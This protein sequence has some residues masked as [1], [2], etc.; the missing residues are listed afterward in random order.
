LIQDEESVV[1]N[2][3]PVNNNSVD[4]YLMAVTKL[5]GDH[6]KI[7]NARL[8]NEIKPL[9]VAGG[10]WAFVKH[11]DWRKDGRGAVMALRKQAEGNSAK[12]TRKAKA[13]VSLSNARY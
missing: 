9:H 6:Y 11:Y 12:R 4:G 13:Y 2:A 7:D 5:E 1:P 3:D 8:Y 10:G